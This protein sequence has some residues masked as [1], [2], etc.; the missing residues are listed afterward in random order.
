MD[1]LCLCSEV[2]G[3]S[4]AAMVEV[5]CAEADKACRKAGYV[6][7]LRLDWVISMPSGSQIGAGSGGG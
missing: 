5:G 6:S 3:C 7:Y 1:G 4:G 2:A